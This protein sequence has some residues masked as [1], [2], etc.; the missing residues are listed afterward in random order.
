MKKAI[1][2]GAGG[3]IGGALARA[4]AEKGYYVYA[5]VRTENKNDERLNHTNIIKVRGDLIE[6]ELTNPCIDSDVDLFF[7]L[8]WSG[9]FAKERKDIDQQK[10]NL[11]MAINAV[12]IAK[13]TN[14][15][16]FI[17]GGSMYEHQVSR[18]N[19]T[20]EIALSSIYGACKRCAG[21]ICEV[22]CFNAMEYVPIAFTNVFGPGDASRRTPNFFI[23]KLMNKHDL[24]LIDGD[25]L[26]DWVYVDDAVQ[27]VIA[28]AEKGTSGRQYLIGSRQIRTFR[29]IIEAVRDVINPGSA[30][31]FGKYKDDSF[32]DF[33]HF[34]L[35]AL[36]NDTGFECKADFRESILK[37]AE[38][39]KTLDI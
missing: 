1:V 36:Y 11:D 13:R 6:S 19:Y 17:F 31:F 29:E 22:L 14:C 28:A 21:T 12:N 27:G 8:A 39:V 2:T 16:R 10:R 37:T 32:I 15:K 35:D 7:H 4:L 30:L 3:F 38:W 33:S 9:V 24:D 20:G 18:T 25:N 23:K 5:V 34:D 26:Y